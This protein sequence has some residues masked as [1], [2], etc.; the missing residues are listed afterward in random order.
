MKYTE[1][2]I[3]KQLALDKK[4]NADKNAKS[5]RTTQ[6]KAKTSTGKQCCVSNVDNVLWQFLEPFFYEGFFAYIWYILVA[7][8]DSLRLP[9]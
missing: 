7:D 9:P 5:G 8:V 1:E 2:N 6:A 3:Q 4:Q